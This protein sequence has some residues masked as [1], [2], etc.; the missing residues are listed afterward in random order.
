MRLSN[1][2]VS[3]FTPGIPKSDDW[4]FTPHTLTDVP[5]QPHSL[6]IADVSPTALTLEWSE[7][8]SDGGDNVSGYII[9]KKDR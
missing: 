7:P 3:S 9:E 6:K 5:S 4:K 2:V 1:T 8:D